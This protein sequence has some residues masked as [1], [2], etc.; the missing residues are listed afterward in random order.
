MA[1]VISLSFP[2]ANSQL[3]LP[4]TVAGGGSIATIPLANSYPF[5]FPNLARTITFTSTDDLSETNIIIDGTDQF[6][7][8]IT[9]LLSGPNDETVESILQYH[10]ITN[11]LIDGDYTNFSIGSG[12]TGTFQW[13]VLNSFSPFASVAVAVDVFGGPVDTIDFSGFQTLDPIEYYRTRATTYEYVRPNAAILLGNDPLSTITLSNIVTVTVPSTGHLSTGDLVTIQG[14]DQTGGIVVNEINTTSFLTVIDATHFSYE[15]GGDATATET[16]GGDTV[17]YIS[18]PHPAA[19]ALFENE[20][21]SLI[22]SFNDPLGAIQII[23]NS[24]TDGA[25]LNI[26]ILQQGI[27]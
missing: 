7:N 10:T 5:V 6:G 23:I 25:G 18:P 13:I 27:N 12:S 22:Q 11:I 16:G 2:S 15:A 8:A 17:I 9:E 20:D 21:A 26:N 3:L 19:F 4:L 1:R 14:A 24:S